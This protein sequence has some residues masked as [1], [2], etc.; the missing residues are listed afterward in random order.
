MSHVVPLLR[1]VAGNVDQV[2]FGLG[3][4]DEDR[5]RLSD[6]HDHLASVDW[7]AWAQAVQISEFAVADYKGRLLYTSAAPTKWKHDTLRVP[8]IAAAYG[9]GASAARLAVVA[10]ADP[11]VVASGILGGTP[12]PGLYVLFTRLIVVGDQP[13]VIFV[14]A[15]PGAR[16]LGEVSLG[17]GTLM[18]LAAPGGAAEGSVPPAVLAAGRAGEID[19]IE[20]DGQTWLVQRYPLNGPGATAMADIV[21]ARQV[22]VGLAGLFPGARNVLALAT[23]VLALA[24]LGGVIEARRRD[25]GRQ[26]PR[27]RRAPPTAPPAAAVPATAPAQLPPPNP[28]LPSTQITGPSQS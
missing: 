28:D 12:R 8:A 5:A 3:T 19:E 17:E 11:D 18:T 7:I 13:R 14:Q 15:V 24:A 10:G 23:C 22:D 4:A 9:A 2:D 25:L 16:L 20:R 27:A 1:E 26:T 6:I 21:L